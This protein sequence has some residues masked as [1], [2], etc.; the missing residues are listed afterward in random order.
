MDL[1]KYLAALALSSLHFVGAAAPAYDYKK[2]GKDWPKIESTWCMSTEQTPIDIERPSEF[3]HYRQMPVDFFPVVKLPVI[4]GVSV[5][6]NGHNINFQFP[7]TPGAILRY[8]EGKSFTALVGPYTGKGGPVRSSGKVGMTIIG[9]NIPAE[10]QATFID[11]H[12]HVP[13]EHS[14]RGKLYDAEA[15]FVHFVDRPEDPD[16]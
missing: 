3:D 4:S 9:V 8:P 13:S 15:H 6:N 12:W 5:N 1:R 7:A 10:V 2:S 14:V 16:W 11:L